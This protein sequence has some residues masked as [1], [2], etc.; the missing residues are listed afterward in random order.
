MKTLVASLITFC[1]VVS[2]QGQS[3]LQDAILLSQ[4]IKHNT[5][6]LDDLETPEVMLLIEQQQKLE[7][8]SSDYKKIESQIAELQQAE[9]SR[10]TKLL[11]RNYLVEPEAFTTTKI[12]ERFT[13]NPY[14]S[15]ISI[16]G[17][18]QQQDKS[19]EFLTRLTQPFVSSPFDITNVAVGLTDFLIE[20]TKTELNTA[21]FIRFKQD[22]K[23]ES[24][25]ELRILFPSTTST[26]EVIDTEIYQYDIY[27]NMLRTSF[28]RDLRSLPRGMSNLLV[29]YSKSSG[30]DQELL[31]LVA[32]ALELSNGMVNGLHPGEVLNV[33]ASSEYANVLTTS[34]TY[35]NI[36]STLQT[37]NLISQSFREFSE[38]DRT[39]WLRQAE[40]NALND[41]ITLRIYLGLL[42]QHAQYNDVYK[43]ISF[44]ISNQE[45][46]LGKL[47]RDLGERMGGEPAGYHL[48]KQHLLQVA[49]TTK[50]IQLQI[51]RYQ[52][53]IQ[54]S[55]YDKLTTRERN[56]L[57][58]ERQSD[59]FASLVGL[60]QLSKGA[61]SSP[62]F[63]GKIALT[64]VEKDAI[65]QFEL[66]GDMAIHAMNKQYS[67]AIVSATM[68][69][70]QVNNSDKDLVLRKF[71]RYGSF[72]AA[73]VEAEDPS[74][75]KAAI[76]AIALPPGS[77]SIKRFSSFSV[78]LNGYLGGFVGN[79]I[80]DNVHR[81]K[82]INNLSLTAPVGIYF[83]WG[84]WCMD[85]PRGPWS[86][87]LS[88]PIIDLGTLASFR[89][90]NDEAEALPTVKLYHIVA[91]GLFAEFGVG[92]TPLTIGV[93]AQLGPRLRNVSEDAVDVSDYY[94][95]V[96][97][98]LKVD[99]PLL[100]LYSSP[101]KAK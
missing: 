24:M 15:F 34:G 44:A 5:L 48:I 19:Q 92:R 7:Y 23:D 68:L 3:I 88:V 64:D 36:V 33:L 101:E 72:M 47:L 14:L 22:L 37:L 25:Q 27:L 90:A 65:R 98:T 54:G 2:A 61:G 39:Y 77:Y 51:D 84:R 21:F 31:C 12:K 8:G 55:D 40:L 11:L 87:G 76:S 91:P 86:F 17:S 50:G 59:V 10:V 81:G 52:G 74:Q 18:P 43:S 69:L 100:N 79:E 67:G 70:K 66:A 58:F 35:R 73:L 97:A 42:Y 85:K 71:L 96:G 28:E 20:R 6:S 46:T 75:A 62:I 60:L 89:L 95:R 53:A 45:F 9:K 57:L 49:E 99:I 41:V 29:E 16:D 78:S 4:T 80:I 63:Q 38:S 1:C 56:R 83:G 30:K 26:L 93:G 13:S 32:L 82:I 94:W